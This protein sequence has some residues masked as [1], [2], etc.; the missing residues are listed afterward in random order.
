MGRNVSLGFSMAMLG[1]EGETVGK[2]EDEIEH[3]WYGK[4]PLD[5]QLGELAKQS[6]V[7]HHLQEQCQCVL[8]FDRD[9]PDIRTVLRAR[10]VN[11]VQSVLTRKT[12]TN[13]MK[14]C[15]EE[16]IEILDPEFAFYQKVIGTGIAKMRYTIKPLGTFGKLELDV[17]V[18]K[19]GHLPDYAYAKYDYEVKTEN[20]PLP[21][22]PITLLEQVHFNPFTATDEE[23]AA[24]RNFMQ[25]Q[26]FRY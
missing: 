12:R 19:F 22:L 8:A 23:I 9:S 15:L 16:S 18:D 14:G 25:K 2:P 6:F 20:D 11:R 24:L 21:P 3:V 7:S 4:L 26:S 1:V 17:F 13:G 5:G 10:R